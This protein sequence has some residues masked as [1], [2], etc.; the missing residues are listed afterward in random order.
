M[1]VINK[2]FLY[3]VLGLIGILFAI[4]HVFADWHD[5]H[6]DGQAGTGIVA[7]CQ[8]LPL[9]N[10]PYIT[11]KPNTTVCVDI[12]VTL[13]QIHAI[14]VVDS[15]VTT[16][17]L[18]SGA[19]AALRR[20]FMLGKL[21]QGG[22]INGTIEPDGVRIFGV[23]ESDALPW[24]LSNAWW[25]KKVDASGN[26]LYPHGN[27]YKEWIEKL[28]ALNNVGIPIQLE[29]CG[30]TLSNAGL[31]NADV[32]SSAKGKIY[33]N[34]NGDARLMYLQQKGYVQIKE[35]WVDSDQ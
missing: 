4:N 26:Q 3:V 20:M 28:F 2:K 29:V 24:A 8:Y 18:P 6:D 31:T 10:N 30:T 12:P 5:Y 11:G 19:P 27:P 17:G 22:I 1:R 25:K 16:N 34:E 35:G 13:A 9:A 15:L 7:P 21:A 32:Y 14:Y 33:V 23:I